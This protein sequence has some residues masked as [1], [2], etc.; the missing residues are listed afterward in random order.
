MPYLLM[1]PA[2][3]EETIRGGRVIEAAE[4]EGESSQ[5]AEVKAIQ[6]ALGIAEQEKWPV[7]Y[8]DSWMVANALWRWQQQWKTTN[9]QCRDKPHL[10]WTAP[11]LGQNTSAQVKNMTGKVNQV[12]VLMPKSCATGEHRNNEQVDK[13]A[14]LN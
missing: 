2:V 8:T 10:G 12:D 6:L 13:A 5:F 3:W 4:G 7:L 11:A 9:W 14:K 1:D